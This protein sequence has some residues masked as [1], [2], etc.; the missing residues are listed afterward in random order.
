MH[1]LRVGGGTKGGREGGRE[2]CLRTIVINR[3]ELIPGPYLLFVCF[4]Q[5]L[6][7]YL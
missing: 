3:D 4:F 5:L 2:G 1:S 6:N 7:P